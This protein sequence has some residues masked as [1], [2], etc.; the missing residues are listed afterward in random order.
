MNDIK[1]TYGNILI[2]WKEANEGALHLPD[3][4][5]SQIDAQNNGI[6]KAAAVGPDCKFVK[7]GDW[8]LL[9]GAGRLLVLNGTT[10]GLIKEHQVDATFKEK[11]ELGKN[12][13]DVVPGLRTEKTEKKIKV[14]N[15][16]HNL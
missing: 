15:E 11:P 12:D 14:F 9:N 4:L 1:L 10:Y 6:T 16:K 8:V 2:E 13:Q 3:E 7:K 5:K